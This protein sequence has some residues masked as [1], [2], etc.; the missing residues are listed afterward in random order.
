MKAKWIKFVKVEVEEDMNN[1]KCDLCFFYDHE[2]GNCNFPRHEECEYGYY[3]L[4]YEPERK[5]R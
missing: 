3:Y 1:G 4:L 5:H 2:T